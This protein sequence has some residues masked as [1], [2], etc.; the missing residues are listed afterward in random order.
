MKKVAQVVLCCMTLLWCFSVL[1]KDNA[2]DDVPKSPVVWQ[3]RNGWPI[4]VVWEHRAGQWFV[5]DGKD[6]VD[7][8]HESRKKA[9]AA[10]WFKIRSNWR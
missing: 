2:T 6:K 7:G 9:D 10:A 5:G 3:H 4:A 1:A 8:P